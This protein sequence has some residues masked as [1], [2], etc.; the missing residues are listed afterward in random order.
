VSLVVFPFKREEPSVVVGN[1]WTAARHERV[2][3][4]LA[5]G[6]SVND[7]YHAVEAVGPE[8]ELAT[9]A[10]VHLILQDRIGNLRPGK[11]DAMNTALEW[12]L[13][14]TDHDRIHFYDADITTFTGEWISRAEAAADL[15]YPVVRHYF[16]RSATDAMITWFVTR[17]G[18]AILWPGTKLPR[19]G[20]PLG[21]ELLF[22]RP[23][24]E[25]LVADEGV[26]AQSDWGIDTRYTIATV[27]AGFPLA[28]TYVP[29]GKLHKLYGSLSDLEAMIVECFS[30]IQSQRGLEVSDWMTHHVEEGVEVPITVKQKVAYDVAGTVR[31]LRAGWSDGQLEL[32]DLFPVDVA[33][34]LIGC[35]DYPRLD[36]MD[37]AAW[38]DTYLVLLDHFRLD[39]QDWRSL[40]FRLWVARVLTYTVTEAVRGYDAALQYL[41]STLESYILR[42]QNG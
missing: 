23:V 36:F 19:I 25:A 26:R 39:D 42:H 2:L 5:V 30:A 33:Q 27:A 18:F 16:P 8:I 1:L 20:Q 4:V 38:H 24:V 22:A 35:R 10:R 37:A 3:D 21:G 15:D 32:L 9:N 14:H 17:T 28:E 40:L 6:H 13:E 12:F 41:G 7:A 34:N 31:L 11:G 29:E